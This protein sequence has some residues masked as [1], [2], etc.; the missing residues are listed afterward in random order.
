MGMF[1]CETEVMLS[2]HAGSQD[3]F[4]PMAGWLAIARPLSVQIQ[5]SACRQ[6]SHHLFMHPTLTAVLATHKSSCDCNTTRTVT[7]QTSDHFSDI[8]LSPPI[9]T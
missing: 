9:C 8:E 1:V 2:S 3:L 7:T 5:Y 4:P 6:S